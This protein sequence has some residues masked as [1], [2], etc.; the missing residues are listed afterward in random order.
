MQW[1]RKENCA[2]DL[3]KNIQS[4]AWWHRPLIPELGRQRQADF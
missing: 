3:L 1:N 2:F 4:R